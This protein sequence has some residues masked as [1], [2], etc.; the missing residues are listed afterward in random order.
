VFAQLPPSGRTECL[1][2]TANHERADTRAAQQL[3]HRL[4]PLTNA[5]RHWRVDRTLP[6]ARIARR[7]ARLW[8]TPLDLR[9]ANTTQC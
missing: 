6:A 8:P 2:I 9:P 7:A 3:H 4:A 5:T 1:P